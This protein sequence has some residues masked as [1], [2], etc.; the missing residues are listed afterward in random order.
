M[1]DKFFDEQLQLLRYPGARVWAT[2]YWHPSNLLG[3]RPKCVKGGVS[4]WKVS[5][6][7]MEHSILFRRSL[8]GSASLNRRP[9]FTSVDGSTFLSGRR[10]LFSSSSF[11]FFSCCVRDRSKARTRRDTDG[12]CDESDLHSRARRFARR[13][14]W[15]RAILQFDLGHVVYWSRGF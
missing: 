10:F 11:P 2:L 3:K 9:Y 4:K 5:G 1:S 8:T 13:E 7:Y 15:R 6:I 12:K 14:K